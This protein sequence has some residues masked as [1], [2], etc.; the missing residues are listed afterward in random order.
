MAFEVKKFVVEPST[1]NSTSKSGVPHYEY[2]LN[3]SDGNTISIFTTGDSIDQNSVVKGLSPN[4]NAN[5]FVTTLNDIKN[6]TGN[7][8]NLETT[9]VIADV[10]NGHELKQCG[11]FN[12][13]DAYSYR[14]VMDC[15]EPSSYV[16][17]STVQKASNSEATAP[18]SV[19]SKKPMTSG[20]SASGVAVA[21]PS[22]TPESAEA[23]KAETKPPA[24]DASK[25]E[26]S[27]ATEVAKATP[28]ATP[29]ATEKPAAPKKDEA[30]IPPSPAK[31]PEQNYNQ[32]YY[33]QQW[34]QPV[35]YG[36]SPAEIMGTSALAGGA[37]GGILGFLFGG[38]KGFW[39]GA[40][41]GALGGLMSLFGGGMGGGMMCGGFGGGY[42][43]GMASVDNALNGIFARGLCNMAAMTSQPIYVAPVQNRPANPPSNLPVLTDKNFDETITK[44]KTPVVVEF[45]MDGCK[46]CQEQGPILEEISRDYSGKVQVYQIDAV[47][48][49]AIKTKYNV[50]LTPTII[51]FKDGKEFKRF[52]KLQSK[53]TITAALNDNSTKATT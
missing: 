17:S 21:K 43:D 41:G 46:P 26:T 3:S 10:P 31:A 8:I 50:T 40:L 12:K 18:K 2:R 36:P 48:E 30:P 47:K 29:A 4:I 5:E 7:T 22:T 6:H 52:E 39:G 23:P 1:S 20:S 34:A 33:Q 11:G 14:S 38:S 28:P 24:T 9:P 27:K 15:L 25:T 51:V 37:I 13:N 19:L 16:G 42:D 44:S 49:D 32:Q 45:V 35:S 53:D